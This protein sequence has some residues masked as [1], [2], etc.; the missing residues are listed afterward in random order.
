MEKGSVPL[1]TPRLGVLI[2]GR[3]TNLQAIVEAIARREI[4]A[5][6]AVVI[7]NRSDA[8]GLASA[9][10]AGIE[11]MVIPHR[12]SPS[13][14]A[15]DGTLVAALRVSRVDLVCLAGFMRQLGPTFCAAFPQAIL[16]IHP[17]LLPAFPGVGAQLHALEHGVK[18]SGAT[19]HFVTPDLDAGPIV[20][21][22]AVPVRD[23]DSADTLAARILVEEHR[24]YP[25][26]IQRVLH[27]RW[28][29]EGRRVLFEASPAP[30][31]YS[32][33]PC[34]RS[35]TDTEVARGGVK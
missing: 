12:E 22:V 23:D 4:D 34:A 17:S 32:H 3:G 14:E 8:I 18:T 33:A 2:S 1:A 29:I 9:R 10:D 16:N 6:V 28:R 35:M 26:A 24:L 13:R 31:W 11:T 25:Q 21:Q 27:G 30:P 7:S 20:A 15:Y 5:T 19:V